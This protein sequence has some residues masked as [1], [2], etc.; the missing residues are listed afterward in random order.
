MKKAGLIILANVL[1]IIAILVIAEIISY[2]IIYIKYQKTHG[3][4][5]DIMKYTLTKKPDYLLRTDQ[6]NPAQ[7]KHSSKRPVLI[8]GCSF[9]SGYNIALESNFAAIL[10]NLTNRSVYDRS[11]CGTGTSFMYYQLTQDNFKTIVPDA[12][13][14]IYVLIYNHFKRFFKYKTDI[15]SDESYTRYKIKNGKLRFVNPNFLLFYTQAQVADDFHAPPCPR[16]N[17]GSA[18]SRRCRSGSP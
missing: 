11:Q 7:I 3:D 13:Y 1:L 15:F 5:K 17:A 9:A 18:P 10:S 4:I 14:I 2:Q 8:F 6:F 16:P 12:E